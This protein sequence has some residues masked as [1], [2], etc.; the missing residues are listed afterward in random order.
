M[1]KV[2]LSGGRSFSNGVAFATHRCIVTATLSDGVIACRVRILPGAALRWIEF[3][4]RVRVMPRLLNVFVSAW[5]ASERR[6]DRLLLAG[7]VA[8]IC[9]TGSFHVNNALSAL[10]ISAI[11]CGAIVVPIL[12]ASG[13][14][15]AFHA[16][17]HKT[18]N[19]YDRLSATDL[20]SIAAQDRYNPMCGTNLI[21]PLILANT[22]APFLALYARLSFVLSL[23][24][25]LEIVL[26]IGWHNVPVFKTINRWLQLRYTTSEPTIRQLE[27]AKTALDAVIAAQDRE[28]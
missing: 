8:V 1:D 18:V 4:K 3:K 11:L 5:I 14:L 25:L 10:A 24:L 7:M 26:W 12:I 6:R 27:V 13:A 16:A 21:A 23:A 22:A 9:T 19:A 20:E 17:E 2:H 28:V 15:T